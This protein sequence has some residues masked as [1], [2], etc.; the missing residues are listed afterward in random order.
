[1]K[2]GP[3]LTNHTTAYRHISVCIKPFRPVLRYHKEGLVPISGLKLVTYA[4]P[5]ILR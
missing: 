5:V 2:E 4:T 3:T 1:M